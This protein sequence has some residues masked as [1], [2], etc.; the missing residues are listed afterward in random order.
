MDL[1]FWISRMCLPA[2]WGWG[3]GVGGGSLSLWFGVSC[4]MMC[5]QIPLHRGATT[6]GHVTGIS[7][8]GR[9]HTGSSPLALLSLLTWTL[10]RGVVS[11]SGQR[12]ECHALHECSL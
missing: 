1:W 8:E 7:N 5:L 4:R 3:L 10:G 12:P 11:R 9:R 2:A 6:A